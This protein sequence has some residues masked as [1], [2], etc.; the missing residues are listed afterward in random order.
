M[1]QRHFFRK[2]IL[3]GLCVALL[4]VAQWSAGLAENP[5]SMP[6]TDC[7]VD[8]ANMVKELDTQ[9][10]VSDLLEAFNVL[11][12]A[13]DYQ[14]AY[15]YYLTH[16]AG[17]MASCW[18][19]NNVG[20]ALLQ[21]GKNKEALT[22]F[23]AI[24]FKNPY[25]QP[26]SLINLLIAGHALGISPLDVL[27]EVRVTPDTIRENLANK[28]YSDNEIDSLINAMCYNVIYMKAE[29]P[30]LT[31]IASQ[32]AQMQDLSTLLNDDTQGDV[33]L[34][35]LRNMSLTD[36]DA[37]NLLGYVEALQTMRGESAVP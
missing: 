29:D 19:M 7:S 21:L 14:G 25:G 33:L 3:P 17:F 35:M 9:P 6:L 10:P 1:K 2:S 23:M 11:Y 5:F 15:V 18:A 16:Q 24:Q 26:E 36:D 27:L 31:A 20:L 8:A 12:R 28:E 22:L 13:G 34:S 32:T 4:C 30:D 37:K